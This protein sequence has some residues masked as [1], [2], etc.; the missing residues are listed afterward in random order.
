M[1]VLRYAIAAAVGYY[2]GQ[3]SG[4]KQLGRLRR[5]VT[6]LMGKQLARRGDDT[7][8]SPA[9]TAPPRADEATADAPTAAEETGR[10]ASEPGAADA[11]T[12]DI[13]RHQRDLSVANNDHMQER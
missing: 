7:A 1:S 13:H 12:S 2:A 6:G 3:P 4:R 8:G 5:R 10:T 9:S 11:R